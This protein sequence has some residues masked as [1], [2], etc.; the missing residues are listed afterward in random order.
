MGDSS[1]DKRYKQ[2]FRT[3]GTGN[4]REGKKMITTIS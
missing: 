1:K 2:Y 3:R 4:A